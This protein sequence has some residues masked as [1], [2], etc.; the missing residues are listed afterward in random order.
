[1]KTYFVPYFIQKILS[2][3]KNGTL[4]FSFFS[5]WFCFSWFCHGTAVLVHSITGGHTHNHRRNVDS[6][7]QTSLSRNITGTMKRYSQFETQRRVVN[8]KDV[9]TMFNARIYSLTFFLP[10][11]GRPLGHGYCGDDGG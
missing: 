6:G 9:A 2:A 7:R 3:C 5:G 4:S 10:L 1:M 11:T 8:F